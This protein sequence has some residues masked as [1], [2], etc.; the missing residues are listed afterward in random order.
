[1]TRRFNVHPSRAFPADLRARPRRARANAAMATSTHRARRHGRT[2]VVSRARVS[3]ASRASSAS[4]TTVS[5][6]VGTA[7][8][9][10]RDGSRASARREAGTRGRDGRPRPRP[11]RRRR[12]TRTSRTRARTSRRSVEGTPSKSRERKAGDK[13]ERKLVARAAD[14]H[15]GV[16]GRW[17]RRC[18]MYRQHGRGAVRMGRDIGGFRL[19]YGNIMLFHALDDMTTTHPRRCNW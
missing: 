7:R 15:G 16:R 12:R 2:S 3:L 1:M 13:T 10:A 11:P 14:A 6:L 17:M 4:T 19:C 5:S 9:R 8:G 18:E